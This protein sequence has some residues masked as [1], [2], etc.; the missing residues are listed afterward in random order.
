MITTFLKIAALL[1]VMAVGVALLM[2]P[3]TRGREAARRTQC[4]NNLKQIMLALHNYHDKYDA[5]PPAYT[6]DCDGNRLHSWRTLI[7]PYLD[8]QLLYST[9]DLSK[10]WND[11][12]NA[13]A[14]K[15]TLHVYCCPGGD[16][17]AT[18]SNHAGSRTTYLAVVTPDS[19][20]RPNQPR[21]IS[22]VNDGTSNTLMIIEVAPEQAVHWM[23]PVDANEQM[24]LTFGAIK[25]RPHTGGTHTGLADGSIRFLS[26]NISQTTLTALISAAGNDAVGDF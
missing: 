17:R 18:R 12:A 3:V 26:A 6:T 13:A 9:I 25:K 21:K 14:Y 2:P 8:Q 1:F 22:E 10:P 16:T 20:F 11:P 24:V 23:E 5:F 19:C 7:L 15:T 4:K